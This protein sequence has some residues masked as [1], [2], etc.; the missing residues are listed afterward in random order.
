M[1]VKAPEVCPENR[2]TLWRLAE[3]Q[4]TGIREQ[5][6]G[7]KQKNRRLT[8]PCSLIPCSLLYRVLV[9]SENSPHRCC[10]CAWARVEA[11]DEVRTT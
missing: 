1:R 10:A 6:S 8:D 2:G 5:G 4:G 3:K 9:L 11:F 7:R